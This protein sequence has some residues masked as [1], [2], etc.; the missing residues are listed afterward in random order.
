MV[1]IRKDHEY[2]SST[3]IG[4]VFYLSVLVISED[5]DILRS[6]TISMIST[7]FGWFRALRILISRTVVTDTYL[8]AKATSKVELTYSIAWIMR[9]KLL[10][11]NSPF[12]S[13]LHT[14]CDDT[15][16]QPCLTI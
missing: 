9:D 4:W 15:T 14:L 2:V 7:I 11:G 5:A 8:S 12:G 3:P 6:T 10:E 1:H 13:D 16:Y